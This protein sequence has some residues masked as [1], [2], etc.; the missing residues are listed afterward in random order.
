MERKIEGAPSVRRADS[1]DVE[2]IAALINSAFRVEAFFI[3]GDR[4]DV[5]EVRALMAKG[6]VLLAPAS[7]GR[8]AACVYLE[9]QGERGYFGLL[10]VDP[11]LQGGGFGRQL[12]AEAEDVCRAAGCEVMEIWVVNLR[13]E[14]P[15]FYR[16]LGYVET[17]TEPF[18]ATKPTKQ[19]CHFLRMSKPL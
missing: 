9:I 2:A 13:Q 10:S 1:G 16:R 7:D 4:I 18:P 8:I 3:E 6:T 14:L 12:V 5:P 19:P 15:P 17:G 11:S